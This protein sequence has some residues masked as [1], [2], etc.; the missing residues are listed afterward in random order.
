MRGKAPDLFAAL[1]DRRITP[2]Y[3]GKSSSAAPRW[4]LARD[5]PRVCGEKEGAN[6]THIA[7][8]WITPAYAGKSFLR[9]PWYVS[10]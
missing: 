2:A 3:A 4:T 10:S 5:H 1:E 8:Y 6:K 7:E 9:L